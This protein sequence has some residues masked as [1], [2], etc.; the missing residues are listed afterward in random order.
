MCFALGS[1]EG[2]SSCRCRGAAQPRA[3]SHREDVVALVSA[4]GLGASSDRFHWKILSAIPL[5]RSMC[6]GQGVYIH[7]HTHTLLRIYIFTHTLF[8]IHIHFYVCI[9]VY[10]YTHYTLLLYR[11]RLQCFYILY[12]ICVHLY[13]VCIMLNMYIH[14]HY[15]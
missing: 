15:K 12:R 2:P 14:T 7:I 4:Q 13:I 5:S 1:V 8:W 6:V 11:C 10:I 3:G 9:E